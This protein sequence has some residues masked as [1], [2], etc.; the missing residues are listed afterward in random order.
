MLRNAIIASATLA[1]A[2][3]AHAGLTTWAITGTGTGTGSLAGLGTI[4]MTLS[5]NIDESAS[6]LLAGGA[7][8]SWNFQLS[9]AYGV[10]YSASGT[11]GGIYG[12]NAGTYV[13][14][15]SSEGSTRRY[16]VVL[17]GTTSSNWDASM[18][19]MPAIASI[20]FGYVASRPSGVYGNIGDSIAGSGNGN[21]GFIM[22]TSTSGGAFGSVSTSSF[23]VVPT[24]GALAL[25]GVAGLVSSRRRRS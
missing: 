14:W 25:A 20:Q 15:T 23:F 9:D 7:I 8:G 10:K 18:S 21:G 1:A 12:N 4:T 24:P 17:G 16:T 13:R 11:P 3:V 6:A 19:G 2:G 5:M 22:A